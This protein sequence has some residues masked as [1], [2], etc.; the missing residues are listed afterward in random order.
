MHPLGATH[1]LTSHPP[2]PH[3]SPSQQA[4]STFAFASHPSS[5]TSPPPH[6]S[7]PHLLTSPFPSPPSKTRLSLMPQFVPVSPQ[8]AGCT[9]AAC[10]GSTGTSSHNPREQRSSPG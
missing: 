7:S 4:P 10:P 9:S 2:P 6:A 3:H 5:E 8:G 1:L